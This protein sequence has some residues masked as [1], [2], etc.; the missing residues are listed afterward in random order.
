MKILALDMATLTGWA[1]NFKKGGSGVMK[2][3]VPR[4]ASPGTRYLRMTKW[5]VKTIQ[6][7]DID[8]VVY[9]LPHQ[10]GGAATEI[11]LG[12]AATVQQVCAYLLIE[13]YAVRADA[14]KIFATGKGNAS[15]EEMVLQSAS[16]LGIVPEDDN[17]ADALWILSW[18]EDYFAKCP[19]VEIK[20]RVVPA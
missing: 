16:K 2:F 8:L 4:G 3:D 11:A 19:N 5:L 18:A 10:R 15:K 13:H 9:E 20:H 12:F 14:I 6:E 7:N 17:H 1:I